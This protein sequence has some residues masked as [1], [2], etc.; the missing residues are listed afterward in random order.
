VIVTTSPGGVADPAVNVTPTPVVVGTV[1]VI[2]VGSLVVQTAVG[3]TSTGVLSPATVAFAKKG[4][5]VP[6]IETVPLWGVIVMAV[7]FPR[8]TV[9][10]EVPLVAWNAAVIVAVPG[11]APVTNPELLTLAVVLAL[12]LHCTPEPRVFVDPSLYVPIALSCT[13]APWLIVA[14]GPTAMEVSTGSTKNP[15]HP[16]P[17]ANSKRLANADPI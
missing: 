9:I 17:K 7:T 4:S 5:D 1:I 10:L 3:E 8:L 2:F 13:V 12:L 16:N 11:A 15:L 14:V 6:L